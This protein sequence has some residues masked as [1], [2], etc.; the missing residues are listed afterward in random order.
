MGRT[1]AQERVTERGRAASAAPVE[2]AAQWK[3]PASCVGL[4]CSLAR[5]ARL[6]VPLPQLGIF[7]LHLTKGELRQL[8]FLF[9]VPPGLCQR[10]QPFPAGC[11]VFSLGSQGAY[12]TACL[13][14]TVWFVFFP[15]GFWKEGC[16]LSQD[17]TQRFCILLCSWFT[18]WAALPQPGCLLF[19]KAVRH[20]VVRP[21][22]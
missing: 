17:F 13:S 2:A 6:R 1:A 12:I 8:V 9:N 22:G 16:C 21:W 10:C 11:D 5:G 14:F 4:R 3:K 20:V 18:R 15:G 7:L 19:P